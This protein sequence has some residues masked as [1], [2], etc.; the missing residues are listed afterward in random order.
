MWVGRA[1][2]LTLKHQLRK[3]EKRKYNQTIL[4]VHGVPLSQTTRKILSISGCDPNRTHYLC[5]E[6]HITKNSTF[7]INQATWPKTIQP[8]LKRFNMAKTHQPAFVNIIRPAIEECMLSFLHV[9][10]GAFWPFT[11]V[12]IEGE[13]LCHFIHTGTTWH[14]CLMDGI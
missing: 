8:D 14:L 12:A 11:Y 4:F 1:E 13:N 3:W 6:R 2:Q 7:G 10:V 9:R 5:M